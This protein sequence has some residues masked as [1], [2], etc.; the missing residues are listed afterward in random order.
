M[1]LIDWRKSQGK[2]QVEMA[3]LLGTDQSR[4]SRYEIGDEIPN[5]RMMLTIWSATG[6]Q[7]TSNDFYDPP[8]DAAISAG[9]PA[10]P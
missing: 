8:A 9:S 5:R 3:E 1:K 2:T 4:I 6:G 7:V 10:E